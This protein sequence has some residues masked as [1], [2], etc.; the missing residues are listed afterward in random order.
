VL[1]EQGLRL[2]FSQ[3]MLRNLL[4]FVDSLPIF[5]LVGG[6]SCLLSKRAQRLGDIAATTIVVRSPHLL[7]PGVEKLMAGKF[8]SFL[9]HP[10]LTARLRQRIAPQE[11]ALALRTL[12]RRD[13][14]EP[15]A[16]VRLFGALAAN[17]K[18]EVAFPP[19]TVEG[20]TDEQYV[21][22]AVNVLFSAEH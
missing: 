3:I 11:A 20:L 13:Q 9:A 21:R 22:N 1:D 7:E 10:H 8:N 4:R 14:F 2:Q 15:E 12:L 18:K 17:L 16:R 6:V 19:E 5:Y